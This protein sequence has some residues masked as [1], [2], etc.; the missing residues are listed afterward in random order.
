MNDLKNNTEY[1]GY[2]HDSDQ[3]NWLWQTLESLGKE[4]IARFLQFVTGSSRIPL[5]GFKAL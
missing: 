5:E 2:Y 1:D 4:D 3:V